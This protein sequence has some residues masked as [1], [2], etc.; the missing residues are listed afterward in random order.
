[1]ENKEELKELLKDVKESEKT[2]V[3]YEYFKKQGKNYSKRRTR[4]LLVDNKIIKKRYLTKK[5]FESLPQEMQEK[6]KRLAKTK[7]PKEIINQL[8][9]FFEPTSFKRFISRYYGK[10]I[11]SLTNVLNRYEE[12]IKEL[13]FDNKEETKEDKVFNICVF[14]EVKVQED[15]H[16]KKDFEYKEVYNRLKFKHF[17]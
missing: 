10:E 1:M 13:C 9:L 2:S 16:I 7:T 11:P 14:L 6:I 17:I 5:F 4:E 15:Y 12:K 3:A 8:G